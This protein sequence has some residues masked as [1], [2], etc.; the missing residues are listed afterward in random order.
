MEVH[1]RVRRWLTG[2]GSD[3][4]VRARFWVEVDGRSHEDARVRKALRSIGRAGWAASLLDYQFSDGHWVT[5][6]TSA[7]ELYR[8]KYI[9]TNWLAI[10]L[11]DL[12]CPIGP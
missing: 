12:A 6:G 1:P 8:P 3:P 7:G 9:V 2:T 5:P 11:A 4:S 10:A